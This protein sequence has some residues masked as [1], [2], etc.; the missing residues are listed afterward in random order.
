MTQLEFLKNVTEQKKARILDANDRIHDFAELSYEE[1]QSADLL[2]GIL[3]EEGFAVER[4]LAGMP[5]CFTGT[6]GSGRP[7]IGILGEFDALSGLSQVADCPVKEALVPGANGH[8]CGHNL[9]GVGSLAAAIAVKKYLEETKVSGTVIYYGCPG[10]EGGAGKAFM[11]REGAFE[12]LDCALTWHPSH[13]NSSAPHSSLANMQMKFTFDGIASHA[14]GAPENGRSAL[15]AVTLMN[16]GVQFLR[17]H[18]NMKDRIHYAV[19]D[20]GGVSPNVVQAH[21]EVIYLVRTPHLNTLF[22]LVERVKNIARGAALMTDTTMNFEVHKITADTVPNA[23]LQKVLRQ[24][25]EQAGLPKFTEEDYAYAKA[26][27]TSIQLKQQVLPSVVILDENLAE[28]VAAH[29]D[30]YLY[31]FLIPEFPYVVEGSGST[32]VGD[33][34]WNTPTAEINTATECAG[35]SMHTWQA[36]AQGKGPIAHKSM[37]FA[38]KA[39]AGGAIDLINDPSLIEAATKEWKRRLNGA[40]YEKLP[41]DLKPRK[42]GAKK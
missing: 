28:V 30:D 12:G 15:D 10:E 32:D 3:A 35:T 34:S 31:D 9:L 33:V 24:N 41:A 6:F 40:V 17:E 8:G 42:A 7:V 4:G 16:T 22:P 39:I 25:M 20:T 19:I 18:T 14:A 38:G 36:T 11:A 27:S 26:M 2:C 37:L 29:K 5:T 21:A 13:I 1:F 23:T